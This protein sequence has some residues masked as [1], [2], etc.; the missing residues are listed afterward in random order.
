MVWSL[1]GPSAG[2]VLQGQRV[3]LREPV[4]ADFAD[5]AMTRR[6]SRDFLQPWEPLWSPQEF[7]V[8]VFRERVRHYRR[9]REA[10][11]AYTFFIEL[12]GIRRLAGGITIGKVQR[13]VADICEL[14]YWMGQPYAGQGYMAESLGLVIAHV[15]SA[16]G[17]HRIEAACIPENTRSIRL[18]EKAGF[19]RE[20]VMRSYLR[21]NGQWRDHYLYALLRD[22]DPGGKT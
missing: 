15:F 4:N 12:N 18:L 1:F 7:E 21:I 13:G 3:T 20:G 9:E 11:N 2:A 8:A 17:L 14:G 6:V 16:L 19:V 5:W 10:G 22:D